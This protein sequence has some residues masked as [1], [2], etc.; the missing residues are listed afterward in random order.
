MTRNGFDRVKYPDKIVVV[1]DRAL[2]GSLLR[3]V[4]I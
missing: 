2:P 1:I 4:G 3:L